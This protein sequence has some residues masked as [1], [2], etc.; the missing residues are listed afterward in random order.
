MIIDMKGI[1]LIELLIVLGIILIAAAVVVPIYGNF[2]AFA[3]LNEHSS[4]LVQILRTA[5]ERS[6]ARLNNDSHGVYLQNDRYILYQGS[7]Y[8]LR[9]SAYDRAVVLDSALSLSWNLSGSGSPGEINFS[10]GLG[11]PDKT[12]TITLI[13]QVQGSRIISIN[14]WGLIEE[15]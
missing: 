8:G 7:S 6:V 9:E 13:H 3:Q 12:G 15:E 2:S 4:Q 14:N 11:L 1:T 5:R 10:K